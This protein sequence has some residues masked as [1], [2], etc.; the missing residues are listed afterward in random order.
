MTRFLARFLAVAAVASLVGSLAGTAVAEKVI[1]PF[2][3]RNLDGWKTQGNVA[4]SAWTVG[5]AKLSPTNPKELVVAPSAGT[6]G[7]LINARAHSVDFYT[8]EKF[9]DARFEME[10]MVPKGS[11]SGIYPLGEYEIQILDSYGHTTLS[12]GDLGGVYNVAAPRVNAAK[13]PGEWQHI[14]IE[15]RAPRFKDGKKVANARFDKVTLNGKVIQE[16]VEAPGP[17]GGGMSGE[18]PTGP[19]KLQGNHG[20]VAFRNI[21]ITVR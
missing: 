16:N 5:H 15:F 8:V 17:T 10:F 11:N 14:V 18:A 9:G 2:N 7:E 3:G 4:D 12:K 20:A 21:R 6:T 19:L 13:K 1:V